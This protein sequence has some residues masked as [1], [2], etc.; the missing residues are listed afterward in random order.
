[1]KAVLIHRYGGP[2]EMVLEEVAAPEIGTQ[3][4]LIRVEI[5]GINFIDVY[6]R[7]GLYS[8][9]DTYAQSLPLG[10][11]MEGAGVVEAVGRDVTNVALGDR[12]AWCIERGSYAELAC[13]PAWKLVKVPDDVSSQTA[14]ALQLQGSTAHYL[15]NSLFP[16]QAGQSCLIHAGAGGLGQ[17]LI[18][19]ARA[20]GARVFTTVGSAEKA[21][22]ARSAGADEVILYRETDFAD[23]VLE[24]TGGE[25][26]HVVYDSVGRDTIEGSFRAARRRG[27]V[28][29]NGNA[30]GPIGAL[31]PL[32]LAE[33]GSLFFTR[34]HLA[35]Y[36]ATAE[37]RQWRAGE[38]FDFHR[39]GKLNVS[40]DRTLLLSEAAE[41]HRL[42][43]GR[44]TRGKLLLRV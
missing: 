19:L 44:Q 25:G 18:Q 29:N 34:P 27:T 42:I 11:G 3:D 35:D 8:R 33:A 40:I 32:D 1:M 10:L 16:L 2:E 22:I 12:V 28:S 7:N 5:A 37:E 41:G 13:V 36:I 31:D 26:V 24:K 43:E 17:I 20:K 21:G 9:S 6:M 39:R 30:S 23:V 38:L 15:T 14:A 4:A